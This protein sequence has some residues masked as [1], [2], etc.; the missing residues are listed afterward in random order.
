MLSLLGRPSRMCDG[1]SRREFLRIGG[2]A[3]GG[4]SMA[5]IFRAEAAQ[6]AVTGRSPSK[7][8]IIMIFLS[9]GPPHQDMVDLKP[10]APAEIRGEFKPIATTLPGVQVCEHL[11]QLAARMRHWALVRSLSHGENGHLPAAFQAGAE[12]ENLLAEPAEMPT[13][14]ELAAQFEAFL[15]ERDDREL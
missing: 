10:D 1:V 2:L 9:G 15:A 14:D 7:K 4:M 5:D 12:R 6:R 11:P 8:A 3:L 13:G